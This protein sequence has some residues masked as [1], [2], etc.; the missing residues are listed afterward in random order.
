MNFAKSNAGRYMWMK[1]KMFKKTPSGGWPC[2]IEEDI[3]ISASMNFESEQ[4]GQ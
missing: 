4:A 1:C 2:S 3:F